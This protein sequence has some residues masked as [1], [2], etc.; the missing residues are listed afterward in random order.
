MKVPLD[1]WVE[2]NNLVD[3]CSDI[4]IHLDYASRKNM[5]RMIMM[6]LRDKCSGKTFSEI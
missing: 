4:E 1:V 3:L 6:S 5:V 2:D